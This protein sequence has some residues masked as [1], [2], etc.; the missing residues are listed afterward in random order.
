MTKAISKQL[1]P[2]YDKPMIYYPLSVLMLAGIR[3][4]LLISTPEDLPLFEQL[5]GDGS[6][7]G[8]Q[9]QYAEQ[10]RPEGLAQAFLIGAEF[11]GDH[12][13]C[14]ILG[15]NLF[16]GHG[17]PELLERA[18]QRNHGGTIFGYQVQDPE[19]YGVVEFDES[20]KALSIE[21]KPVRPKSHFAVPGLYFLDNRVVEVAS[22]LKPSARGE[23]EIADV[24]NFYLKRG[25]LQVE[26][27]GRGFAWL[28]TGTYDSLLSAGAFIETLEKRQGLKVAC[29]EEIALKKGWIDAERL[30][31]TI[32]ELAP[33]GYREYLEQLLKDARATQ[34][35]GPHASIIC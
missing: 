5:L 25:E 15:D 20:G 1:L 30:S 18:V 31:R 7:W 23:L 14:L 32:E 34:A 22:A 10:P 33:C 9:L 6:Q 26:L 19:R 28:D 29:L 17:F 27:M 2:V 16:F 24:I 11:L 4:A 8:M 3:D 21:E 12:P 13:A 35:A